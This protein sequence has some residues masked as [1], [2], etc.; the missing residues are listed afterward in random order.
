[1]HG[2]FEQ[3]SSRPCQRKLERAKGTKNVNTQANRNFIQ[4]TVRNLRKNFLPL[5][6]AV[7]G[8][9]AGVSD[10]KAATAASVDFSTGYTAAN[11]VS[12]NGWATYGTV[13]TSPIQV[14]S[15]GVALASVASAQGAY[16]QYTPFQFAEA[17]G[18]VLIRVDI[19][20]TAASATGAD[21][22]LVTREI[23]NS[24]TA[25]Q[26]QPTG[27]SYFRTYLK[28]SGSGFV[29]GWNP[30]GDTAA[31]TPPIYDT[32]VLN[33]NQTYKLLIRCD[34]FTGRSNDK[35]YLCVDPLY[36]SDPATLPWISGLTRTTWTGNTDEFSYN[37]S[38]GTTAGVARLG[39]YLNLVVKQ[40]SGNA[41]T[42]SKLMV[43]DAMT[44]VGYVAP[45]SGTVNY[46][47]TATTGI[48]TWTTSA[49]WSPSVPSSATN[50]ALIFNG[51]LTSALE[52]SNNTTG[53]FKLNSLT[54]ANTGSGNL[55]LTGNPLQFVNSGGTNPILAF[56]TAA[57]VLQSVG[58][59]LQVDAD[60]TVKQSSAT[61]SNSTIAG[62]ISGSGGLSKT[63]TGYAYITGVNNSFGGSV[64]VSAGVLGATSL[65][66]SGQT[67]SLGTNGTVYLGDSSATSQLR[68]TQSA[69]QT[70]DKVILLGG[71]GAFN[72][73]ENYGTT[74]TVLTLSG[75]IG[76]STNGVKSLRLNPKNGPIIVSGAIGANMADNQL[77]LML[78]NGT[79]QLTLTRSNAYNGGTYLQGGTLALSNSC[80]IGTGVVNLYGGTITALTNINLTNNFQF[81]ASATSSIAA[82]PKVDMTNKVSGTIA[83]YS[84]GDAGVV[85]IN[86]AFSTAYLANPSNT[87]SSVLIS[88]GAIAA[89]SLGVAGSPSPLGTNGI[90]LFGNSG[91][92]ILKYL[93]SGETNA[94][95]LVFSNLGTWSILEHRGTGPLKL[96]TPLQIDR[97]TAN[98]LILESQ[99]AGSGE[100]AGSVANTNIA[101]VE[102]N[103]TRL[104]KFG[105]GD[106]ILSASNNYRNTSIQEGRLIAKDS[107]ALP[108]SRDVE[109]AGGTLLV[110]YSGTGAALGNLCLTNFKSSPN[111]Y[112]DTTV[113]PETYKFNDSTIDLGTNRS[114]TLVFSSATNWI[115]NQT[116]NSAAV[117]TYGRDQYLKVANSTVGG[118]LYVTNTNAVPLSR[119]VCAE[120]TNLTAK[121]TSTGLIYFSLPNTAPVITSTGGISVPENKTAV[122]TVTA[123]DAEG[124]ALTYSISGGL[125]ADKFWIDSGTGV[126]TFLSAPDFESPTDAGAD[127]VYNVTVQVTDGALSTTKDI[128][129]TV[130]NVSD[131]PADFKADW[132]A[133]NG[134][135]GSSSWNSDPNNVGYSLATAYAFG[136]SP[137]VRGGAPAALASSSVGSVKIVY[138]QKDNSG[139][140]YTVKSGTDLAAGLSGSVTPVVSAVQPSIKPTGYTQYE[141]TLSGGAK[142]FLKVQAIVP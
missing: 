82:M 97:T 93:G 16:K 34:S 40:Q 30:H 44:D 56:A 124:N 14:S 135:P 118:S 37:V 36:A 111:R 110:N 121:I 95:T 58:N 18:T 64:T 129:V 28:A 76:T 100:L 67:S 9:L 130:T 128:A 19:N 42:V 3:K 115:A 46:T 103:G 105:A 126:L 98:T 132:L 23:D 2:F 72:Y 12:Q 57:T 69:D 127:N 102:I 112:I 55:N 49:N 137:S 27:K 81:G 31:P 78:T 90:I 139:V 15:S 61:V 94:K 83:G 73:I 125:D 91:V 21:F 39:G 17:G 24:G 5:V 25:T 122:T 87:F 79:Y 29:L 62:I 138:L 77:S 33:F 74:G 38:S 119:I 107:K 88:Q 43:G 80:A 99:P 84:S 101:D 32:T 41:L 8:I 7:A 85:R 13:T 123:T 106:W 65:G 86:T 47:N 120:N 116:A 1:M 66:M 131:S 89:D 108:E 26:G 92:G 75:N 51:A 10:G 11:L 52:V 133:A 6:L 4:T 142:G 104:A 140:T 134:L 71:S 113:V 22:F 45:P 96:T 20:V 114:A 136:L 109:M 68:S 70:S 48:S 53:N 35:S 63:G 141:G 60:L 117:E 50:S 54:F 59:N